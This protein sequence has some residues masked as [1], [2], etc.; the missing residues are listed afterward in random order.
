M[1]RRRTGIRFVAAAG[2]VL[3]A[4]GSAWAGAKGGPVLIDQSNALRGGVTSG[5]LP[6]FPVSINVPGSYRLN[7]NLDVR[8]LATPQDVDVIEINIQNVDLDLAG[9][10]ILGPVDCTGTGPTLNCMPAGFGTGIRGIDPGDAHVHNGTVQGMGSHG[11]HI[12][13][14]VENVRVL[15][16]AGNGISVVENAVECQA[17]RN[18][19]VGIS[20]NANSIVQGSRSSGNGG[21]GINTGTSSAIVENFASGNGAA[22]MV[23]GAGSGFTRN[24]VNGNVG[25]TSGGLE[26]GINMCDGAPGCP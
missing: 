14:T 10:S 17:V 23:M 6:G 25:T 1:R 21:V 18:D 2:F 4:C 11:V 5:D 3:V 12:A 16:N 7:S 15:E 22:G 20:T 9:F 24:V 26:T 19:G 8:A 13:G